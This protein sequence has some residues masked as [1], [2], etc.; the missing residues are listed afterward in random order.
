VKEHA[1]RRIIKF[2][3]HLPGRDRSGPQDRLGNGIEMQTGLLFGCAAM[4]VYG[5]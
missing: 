3:V 2:H 4:P 1:L 5:T